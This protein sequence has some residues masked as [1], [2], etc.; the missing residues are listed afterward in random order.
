MAD[1]A[2]DPN[3]LGERYHF[4]I[5]RLHSLSGIVPVGVFLCVHMSVNA[6]V[7]AGPARFQFAVDQIHK[8]ANLGILKPVEVLFI[9]LPIAFH[10]YVGAWIWLTGKP[11]IMRY[12]H[13]DNI[14]YAVQRWTGIIAIVFILAHLW[15]VHWIIPGGTEFDAHAAAESAVNAMASLWVGPVYALGVL[16]AVFHFA[17]G[18]WTFLITWGVTIGP[19]SQR[20]SGWVC[21]IIGVVLALMGLAA[22]AKF[23][24]MDV[25][26]LQ[27]PPVTATGKVEPGAQTTGH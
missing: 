5:R 27:H 11:E 22:L 10:A 4:L 23:K 12:P 20:R 7:L 2:V 14:R 24:S 26:A 25:S 21:G 1:A 19:G 15:H 8:L 16:C 18:I 9:F 6:S 13:L 17:N 3:A